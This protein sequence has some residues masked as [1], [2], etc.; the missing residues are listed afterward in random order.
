VKS[1]SNTINY[2]LPNTIGQG[3]NFA[4]NQP[5]IDLGIEFFNRTPQKSAGSSIKAGYRLGFSSTLG[6]KI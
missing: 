2:P 3:V 5:F 4:Q 1:S 6:T